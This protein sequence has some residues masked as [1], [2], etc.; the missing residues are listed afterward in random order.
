MEQD[1]SVFVPE[2]KCFCWECQEAES[3]VLETRSL[4]SPARLLLV[5]PKK[6]SA[7]V[8]LVVDR[9]RP[10]GPGCGSATA[11]GL[12]LEFILWGLCS[13]SP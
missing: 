6:H 1:S 5:L 7:A 9:D 8:Y 3:C 4:G 2:I 13:V 12:L 11:V 10:Q